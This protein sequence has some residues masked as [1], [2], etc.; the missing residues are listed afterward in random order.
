MQE[1]Q[2]HIK[3]EPLYNPIIDDLETLDNDDIEK[4]AKDKGL[5]PQR[6]K[7]YKDIFEIYDEGE[8]QC[9]LTVLFI[10]NSGLVYQK[11]VD[12]ERGNKL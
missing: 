12:V 11:I 3:I 10:S 9:I 4:Y 6:V 2:M 1:K 8:C 5:N 7:L